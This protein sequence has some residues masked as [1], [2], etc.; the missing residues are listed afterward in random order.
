MI[1]Q[2]A[3]GLTCDGS[4]MPCRL[5]G[6]TRFRRGACD[7]HGRRVPP[8][9]IANLSQFEGAGV[10]YAATPMEAQLCIGEESWSSVAAIQPGR[11][12]YFSRRPPRASTCWSAGTD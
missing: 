10:Y 12:R 9:A 2:G 8:A 7:R 5:D 1:A 4:R 11:P 3:T 6:G